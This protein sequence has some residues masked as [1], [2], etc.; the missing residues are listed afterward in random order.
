VESINW[1]FLDL[2]GVLYKLDYDGVLK[3]F[4]RQSGKTPVEL[5]EVL[6]DYDL[7][8]SF[9][10][11]LISSQ[12][13]HRRITKRIQCNINFDEFSRIWNSLL[14][15]QKS[16][17][18]LAHRLKKR[19]GLLILSNTNEMNATVIDPDIRGLTDKVVYS[20]RV[21]YMKPDPRIFREALKL[22]GAVPETTL[23][24][25]DR[26]ENIEGARP[27]GFNTHHFQGKRTLLRTIREYGL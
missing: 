15:P 23:F 5:E 20:H 19:V 8:Y 24:I 6:H 14:I 22:S 10:S 2:G 26:R 27:L 17:F 25:D 13:F 9:E 4:C 18:R 12:D 3:R 1:I 7:F 16:M 11:G 21:G